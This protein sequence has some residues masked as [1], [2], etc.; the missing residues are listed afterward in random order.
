MVKRGHWQKATIKKIKNGYDSTRANEEDKDLIFARKDK[1]MY[2]LSTIMAAKYDPINVKEVV[3]KQG[4]LT[5]TKRLALEKYHTYIQ[6]YSKVN[7]AIGGE[8]LWR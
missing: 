7:W 2:A 1:E 6:S 3:S 5:I 4:H 8:L